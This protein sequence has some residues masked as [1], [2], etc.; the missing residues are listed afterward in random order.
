MY[1][2][3][4]ETGKLTIEDG[5]YVIMS[6]ALFYLYIFLGGLSHVLVLGMCIVY[7][8]LSLLHFSTFD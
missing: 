3:D 4:I 8:F 7:S 5:D 2:K 6:L 1:D